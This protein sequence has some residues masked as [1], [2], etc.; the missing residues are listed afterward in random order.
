RVPEQLLHRANVRARLEQMR[1]ERMPQRMARRTFVNASTRERHA[2]RTLH[3]RLVE[4]VSA[5]HT[6]RI[7]EPTSRRA[8]ILPAPVK[9]NAPILPEQR[10]GD[11]G[12]PNVTPAIT[13]V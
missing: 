12:G 13:V 6:G 2:K 8:H 11:A 3:H 7:R 4:V 1:C 5:P 10:F 9:V